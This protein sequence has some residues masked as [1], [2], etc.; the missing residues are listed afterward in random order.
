MADREQYRN[1][2]QQ[3]LM[4]VVETLGARPIEGMTLRQ[5]VAALPDLSQDRIYRAALNV[6]MYGWA[7][8]APGGGWRLTPALTL[9][10]Q[11]MRMALADMGR[12]YLGADA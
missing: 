4:R 11:R 2:S 5:L 12:A 6:E 9:F 10:S 1:G 3:V 8:A 7:E